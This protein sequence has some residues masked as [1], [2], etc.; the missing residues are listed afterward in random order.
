MTEE[1]QKLKSKYKSSL[2][3]TKLI[4]GVSDLSYLYYI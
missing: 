4:I 1:I 2:L 3:Q